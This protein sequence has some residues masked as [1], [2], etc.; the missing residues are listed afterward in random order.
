[1]TRL[2]RTKDGI[3][4]HWDMQRDLSSGQPAHGLLRNVPGQ[5]GR[6]CHRERRVR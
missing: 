2:E 4:G 5:E 3:S 1:M 6:Q